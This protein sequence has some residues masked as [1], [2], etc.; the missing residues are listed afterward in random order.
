[1]CINLYQRHLSMSDPMPHFLAHLFLSLTYEQNASKMAGICPRR[2]MCNQ[3]IFDPYQ[4]QV[5]VFLL[6][7]FL[8][9]QV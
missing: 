8:N 6:K 4:R 7:F 1:M 2:P 9:I 3:A 5:F